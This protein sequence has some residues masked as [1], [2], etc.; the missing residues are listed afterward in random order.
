MTKGKVQIDVEQF[1]ASAIDRAF[2]RIAEHLE[3][4]ARNPVI[5]TISA[6]AALRIEARILREVAGSP[7]SA[8]GASLQWVAAIAAAFVGFREDGT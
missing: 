3:E 4:Q 7:P 5:D 2:L 6:S 8:E 1:L